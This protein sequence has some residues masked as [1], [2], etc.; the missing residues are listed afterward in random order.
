MG[1]AISGE[2]AL[3]CSRLIERAGV[4]FS[5]MPPAGHGSSAHCFVKRA[6]ML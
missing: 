4:G 1:A 2:R 6:A 5:C 3:L